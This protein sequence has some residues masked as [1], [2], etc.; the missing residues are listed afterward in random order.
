MRKPVSAIQNPQ[1]GQLLAATNRLCR[2]AGARRMVS[3][4][5]GA[6]AST[7]VT[8]LLMRRRPAADRVAAKEATGQPEQRTPGTGTGTVVSTAGPML[9]NQ[10]DFAFSSEHGSSFRAAH[11]LHQQ[12]CTRASQPLMVLCV[13][14][15]AAILVNRPPSPPAITAAPKATPD[16]SPSSSSPSMGVII[17]AA[18]GGVV[19]V[20]VL[21]LAIVLIRRHKAKQD[22]QKKTLMLQD[23]AAADKGT[24]VGGMGGNGTPA[25]TERAEDG[26]AKVVIVTDNNTTGLCSHMCFFLIDRLSAHVP[27]RQRVPCRICAAA[28]IVQAQGKT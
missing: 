19:V 26:W 2:C 15:P 18:V 24:G 27:G 22:E 17:G 20:A 28:W 21:V 11:Q 16:P 1:H 4:G 9:V 12:I 14:C 25:A 3:T 6:P 5:E 8:A 7:Q 13:R 23:S 10:G